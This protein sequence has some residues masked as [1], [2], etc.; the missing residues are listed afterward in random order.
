MKLTLLLISLALTACAT[1][2]GVYMLTYGDAQGMAH[3]VYFKTREACV[4]VHKETIKR[5]I[6]SYQTLSACVKIEER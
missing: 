5:R 3:P 6:H 2:G 1:H 4:A